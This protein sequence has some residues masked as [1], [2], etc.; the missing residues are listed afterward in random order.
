M[1]IRFN[2]FYLLFKKCNAH[3]LIP[4]RGARDQTGS[5]A[6]DKLQAQPN[7]S[8]HQTILK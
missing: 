4:F 5:L 6:N 8:Y 3:I 7:M 1:H 2:L